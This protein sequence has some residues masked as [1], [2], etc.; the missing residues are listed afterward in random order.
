MTTNQPIAPIDIT[1]ESIPANKKA[2]KLNAGLLL[3][4]SPEIEKIFIQMDLIKF[5][6]IKIL[7]G[8]FKNGNIQSL[9]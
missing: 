3:Q 7:F 6:F 5:L 8:F 4:I 9:A 2:E 1:Q